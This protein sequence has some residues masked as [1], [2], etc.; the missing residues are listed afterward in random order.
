MAFSSDGTKMF[1]VGQ[2]ADA[3]HEYTLT[4]PFD[5]TDVVTFVDSFSV[6]AQNTNPTDVAFSS[7]GTKMFVVDSDADEEVN[8]YTLTSGFDVST[9]SFV[10]S[11]SVSAQ[12][13]FPSGVAFSSDGTKMFVVGTMGAD[14]NEYTLSA[15]FTLF[16]TTFV[17]SFSVTGQ[18][19]GPNAIAFSSDGTKMFVVGG[20]GIDVNEYTLTSAFDVSTASFVGSFSI[21]SQVS[22][23]SGIAFS[24][25]GTK[26]FISDAA[27][28]QQEIHVYNI[29]S[30]TP[31]GSGTWTITASCTM[32]VSATAL[33]NVL[34]E[35]N[36]V[37]TIPNGVTLNIDFVNF[38]LTIKS[39]SGV[40]IESGGSGGTI[41]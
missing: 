9:A 1:V 18:D 11:F 33:G 35:N 16:H 26:V 38:N 4:S 32:T 5:L 36:S 8:E 7:D 30:C 13:G 41:T 22:S 39:G 40:L 12:D 28:S 3:V 31:Q 29:T 20:V 14:V 37:L 17:D 6:V 15:A 27:F 2:S 19:T 21:A 24:S 34:V 25:D 10:D 23:P